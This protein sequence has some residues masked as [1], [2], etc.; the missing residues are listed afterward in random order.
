MGRL[1]LLIP[2][3]YSSIITVVYHLFSIVRIKREEFSKGIAACYDSTIVI[4]IV[5]QTKF[6]LELEWNAITSSDVFKFHFFFYLFLNF[7]LYFTLVWEG[8]RI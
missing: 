2:A 1:A 7:Y 4:A 3:F 5:T 6:D 8:N